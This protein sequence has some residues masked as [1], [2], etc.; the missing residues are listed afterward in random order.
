MAE[1]VRQAREAV[2]MRNVELKGRLSNLAEAERIARE[3]GGRG[4]VRL[5][6][7]DTYFGS[8]HG[9]LKLRQIR[10]DE[11]RAELIFYERGDVA[12]VRGS[13]YLISPV[14]DPESLK[15]ALAAALGVRRVVEK[16]RTLYLL[17]N[18]RIHLDD[19]VGLGT[20][21]ELEAV[22]DGSVEEGE[23]EAVV[24]RLAAQFG[25][26]ETDTLAGSYVDLEPSDEA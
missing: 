10:G 5:L 9:R 15:Q 14:R 21:L 11:S 19:V 20:F 3:T 1:R 8:H 13:D 26:R 25:I 2:S 18:V 17:G 22:L 24:G 23:G 6:Q 4:P 16:T 12:G 7:T